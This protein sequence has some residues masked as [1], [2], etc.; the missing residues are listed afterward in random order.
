MSNSLSLSKQ[1][2]IYEYVFNPHFLN[3]GLCWQ[4][5]PCWIEIN[6][7]FCLKSYA[8]F[9]RAEQIKQLFILKE[10]YHSEFLNTKKITS[11]L[12]TLHNLGCLRSRCCNTWAEKLKRQSSV[13]TVPHFRA[14]FPDRAG[15]RRVAVGGA[16]ASS[17]STVPASRCAPSTTLRFMCVTQK[18]TKFVAAAR[19]PR[20]HL[21]L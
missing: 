12:R 21:R 19:V 7:F 1:N 16:A 14:N 6:L 11:K 8:F 3:S 2:K 9:T 17:C 10:M 15:T 13:L 18:W 5:T 4:I 20:A